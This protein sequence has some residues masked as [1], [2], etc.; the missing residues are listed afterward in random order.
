MDS[1]YKPHRGRPSPKPAEIPT[2]IS[3]DAYARLI[4]DE[5]TTSPSFLICE[6]REGLIRRQQES[7]KPRKRIIPRLPPEHKAEVHEYL[8]Q[9]FQE[10]KAFPNTAT[11]PSPDT[12]EKTKQYAIR[13]YIRCV[14]KWLSKIHKDPVVIDALKR[15]REFPFKWMW[16]DPEIA[17]MLRRSKHFGAAYNYMFGLTGDEKRCKELSREAG[18]EGPPHAIFRAGRDLDKKMAQAIGISPISARLYRQ[19][20]LRAGLLQKYGGFHKPLFSIGKWNINPTRSNRLRHVKDTP[21]WREKLR[22]FKITE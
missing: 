3:D 19:A 5:P 16:E 14:E 9:K 8:D 12:F 4:D 7:A 11:L 17:K 6:K 15:G 18:I 22:D 2:S 20:F 1:D 13:D 21:E 10:A